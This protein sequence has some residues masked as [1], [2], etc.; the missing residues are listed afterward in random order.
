M[1]NISKNYAFSQTVSFWLED[2]FTFLQ[3]WEEDLRT[4][5]KEEC[6]TLG[7]ENRGLEHWR[8]VVL[9]EWR[10]GKLEDQRN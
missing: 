1:S 8:T 5:L 9:E 10:T 3:P 7:L 2:N 6:R 4:E